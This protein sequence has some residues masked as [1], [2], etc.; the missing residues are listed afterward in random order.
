MSPQGD[1]EMPAPSN[2]SPRQKAEQTNY[3]IKELG[4]G[5]YAVVCL[6][7]P[8]TTADQIL[9]GYTSSPKTRSRKAET[10]ARLRTNL[11]AI[12]IA[13][14]RGVDSIEAEVRI[15]R[16]LGEKTKQP[17]VS[18][19]IDADDSPLSKVWYTMSVCQCGDL[20]QLLQ[21]TSGPK[22][23]PLPVGLAWHICTQLASALLYLHFGWH[24][25]RIEPHWPLMTHE[26]IWAKNILFRS[27]S[28]ADEGSSVHYPD[29]V[30]AD[31]GKGWFVQRDAANTQYQDTVLQRQHRDLQAL[32]ST[33]IPLAHR[34]EDSG[35]CEALI[36]LERVDRPPKG[37][38]QNVSAYR[39]LR[40]FVR[41]AEQRRQESYQPLSQELKAHFDRVVV[42]DAELEQTFPVLQL[43]DSP[44]SSPS[45][46]SRKR[47]ASAENSEEARLGRSTRRKGCQCV[48]L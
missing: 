13:I 1:T 45:S 20:D 14:G 46:G 39:A 4:S 17:S 43:T 36:P 12:K 38:K 47:R 34:L 33:L 35:L 9:E 48:T 26:D 5:S 31:F 8:R 6:S 32:A 3:L 15:L 23:V 2:A 29:A 41:L 27:S 21:L 24:G 37:A 44:E 40:K 22:A 16:Q 19:L 11:Q 42:T 30:L 18:K 7:I 25:G 10:L 28:T